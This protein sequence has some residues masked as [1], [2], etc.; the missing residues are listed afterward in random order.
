[1]SNFSDAGVDTT[2]MQVAERALRLYGLPRNTAV[3]LVSVSENEVY[4]VAAPDGRQWALRLQ[5]PGYQST[6]SLA[7]EIA[8]LVALR[9]DG[10]V[11]TPIP[12]AGLDGDWVQG[13]CDP[14]TGAVRD[15]VL[16]AWEPG[17]QP[18]ISMDLHPCFRRLG[19]I[20][21]RMHAH[22]RAWQRPAQFTRFSWDVEAA[23]G[24]AGR[25]GRWSDG[26][27]M[28]AARVDLFGKAVALVRARLAAFGDGPERFGLVHCDLRLA[29]LLLHQGAVKVIDFDDCGFS[30]FMSDIANCVSFYEHLPQVPRLIESLLEGYCTVGKVSQAD[31]D[32]IPTFLMLRRLLLVAWVGSHVETPLAATLGIAFTDQTVALC[33]A[34]LQRFG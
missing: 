9:E 13:V 25:W 7:S 34:Y 33:S 31:K 29:N 3:R 24:E 8:W 19:A 23:L 28:N 16:F 12:Y 5:R 26:L 30:W 10:V 20:I 17:I 32:E 14:L 6:R 15:V 21:A 1:M 11:A 18:A 4:H 27:G 22:S 2:T